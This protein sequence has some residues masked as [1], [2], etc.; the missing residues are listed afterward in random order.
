MGGMLVLALGS[1]WMRGRIMCREVI[2]RCV[3]AVDVL[4]RF[5][6]GDDHDDLQDELGDK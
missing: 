4:E 5:G 1:G 3:V 2:V 6:E